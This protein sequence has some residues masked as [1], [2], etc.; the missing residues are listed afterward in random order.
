MF[1]T[2]TRPESVQTWDRQR[3]LLVLAGACCLVAVVLAGLGL[4]IVQVLS[5]PAQTTGGDA[6]TG[7]GGEASPPA[8]VRDKIAAAPM[9]TVDPAAAT[10]PDPALTLAAPVLIPDSILGRGPAGIPVFGH[11]AEGALAQLAAI[12]V[13]VLEAMDLAYAGEVHQLWVLQGGPSLEEWDLAIN[14][15]AFLRGARQGAVKD[16]TTSVQVA[17]AGGLVKGSDGPDWLVACVLLDVQASIR[18]DYRM[19]WG[20]CARMQW[21]DS[22]WQ[23]APGDP[24]SPAP[25]AWPGSKA[26]IAAGWLTWTTLDDGTQR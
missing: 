9:P 18:D 25:S 8:H 5:S 13:A 3:L 1:G 17:P 26:A 21:T 19:G 20:H 4:L 23:I 10:T 15:A 12:D 16:I 14:V 11:T 22:R 6:R 2:R 7:G 24:P